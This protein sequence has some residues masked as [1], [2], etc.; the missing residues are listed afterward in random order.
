MTQRSLNAFQIVTQASLILLFLQ[1]KEVLQHLYTTRVPVI[2]KYNIPDDQPN[3]VFNGKKAAS[4][5]K[6]KFQLINY[7][8][9]ENK[10]EN[11][12]ILETIKAEARRLKY[13]KNKT[14]VIRIHFHENMEYGQ[15]L[16]I[17]LLMKE[18]GHKR[19]FEWDNYFYILGENKIQTN[20]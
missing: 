8:F 1:F 9:T 5:I 20:D 11:Q 7:Q 18:D 12:K 16:Q 4:E 15:F 10:Y 17:L 3:G 19:Y 6:R 13:T 2:I 14:H